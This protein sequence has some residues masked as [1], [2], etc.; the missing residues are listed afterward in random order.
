MFMCLFVIYSLCRFSMCRRQYH[1][2][3]STLIC[4]LPFTLSIDLSIFYHSIDLLSLYRSI[5]LLSIYRSSIDLSIFYHSIDLS[6]TLSLEPPFCHFFYLPSY[7]S[8]YLLLYLSTFRSNYRS[9]DRSTN[10]FHSLSIYLV[11]L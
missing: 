9:I 7:R 10:L 4:N 3:R 8:I 11:T 2:S 6:I 5:D 1:A